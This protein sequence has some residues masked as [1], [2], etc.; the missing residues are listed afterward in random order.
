MREI[1]LVIAA[2]FLGLCL[3]LGLLVRRASNLL[4]TQT[5]LLRDRSAALAESF[6]AL[7]RNTLE[8]VES[9]NATVEAKDPYTAGHSARVQRVSLA[10][11]R[12][13]RLVP[14]K[15]EILRWGGL[16]HDIGKI[17][18]PDAILLKPAR[19]TPDEFERMKDHSAEGARIVGKL[20]HLSRPC[21]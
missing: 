19:L 14:D 21:R 8:A 4:R 10:I 11:G 7:E 20:G 5:K 17:A 6:E 18:V 16:F 13:L 12:E 1:W 9:L 15:L 3:A 2:V